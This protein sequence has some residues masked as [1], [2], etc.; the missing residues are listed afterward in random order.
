MSLTER[1]PL[2]VQARGVDDDEDPVTPM[3]VRVQLDRV[4]DGRYKQ[5][6][7]FDLPATPEQLTALAVGLLR[8][9][10]PFSEREWTGAGRPFSVNEFRG[11]RSEMIKRQL[12]TLKNEKDARQG[13]VPTAEGQAVLEQFLPPK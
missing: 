9:R 11:L 8:G 12:M 3:V 7:I 5:T 1:E 13:Y 10:I 6:A 2:Q 4:E